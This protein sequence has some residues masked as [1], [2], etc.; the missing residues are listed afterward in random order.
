MLMDLKAAL[1]KIRELAGVVF[2]EVIDE[3]RHTSHI[4]FLL[5]LALDEEF[6]DLA[7]VLQLEQLLHLIGDICKVGL[8]RLLDKDILGLEIDVEGFLR[9]AEFPAYIVD[10]NG[11]DTKAK[12]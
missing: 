1:L 6:D 10:G 5:L 8:Q 11:T 7:E 2:L 9:H 12:E 3:L 4:V